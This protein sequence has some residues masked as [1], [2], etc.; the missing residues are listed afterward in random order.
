MYIPINQDKI[1]EMIK[2]TGIN[3][4]DDLFCDIPENLKFLWNENTNRKELCQKSMI[5]IENELTGVSLN[6][7]I[8]FAGGGIYDHYIPAAVDF[9]SNRSEFFTAYTPYQPEISQ[10]TL[11]Y[12][13]EYQTAVCELTKLDIS[14]A[15]LYDGATAL[16]ESIK[17]ALLKKNKKIEGTVL[18]PSSLNYNFKKTI[19]TYLKYSNIQFIEIPFDQSSGAIDTEFLKNNIKKAD[20]ICIQ[21]PNYFGIIEN[22][23]E[24]KNIFKLNESII[25]IMVYYPISL[26]LLKKPGEIGFDIAV[27]EGQ[28]L[29]LPMSAGGPLLGVISAKTDFSRFIPGRIVGKTLDK[30]GKTGY[31]LTLQT[32][33][34]HIRREKAMS[35]ICSNE[36]L[37][38]LRAVVYMSMLGCEGFKY[39]SNL[40]Y[41]NTSYFQEKCKEKGFK[42]KFKS[43]VFNE[44][45]IQF[46]NEAELKTFLYKAESNG[47]T[48]GIPLTINN[49]TDCLLVSVTEKID[50]MKMNK[51]LSLK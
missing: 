48:A 20:V 12:I 24:L 16:I 38:A 40:L 15:S 19:D 43:K 29:G 22:L 50:E 44:F 9:I 49:T 35:N 33:E 46:N 27:A 7:S 26:G 36:S 3:K 21:S 41:E 45:V 11:Q 25:K 28:C 37:C 1:N 23:E 10:G 31:V 47:I 18:L 2:E 8:C 4:I 51:F 6:P 32:R 14:N 39:L 5:E 17:M 13:F 42:I 34:Q 30:D